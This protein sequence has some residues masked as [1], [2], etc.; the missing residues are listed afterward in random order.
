MKGTASG[1]LNFPQNSRYTLSAW[2]YSN[3]LDSA[4]H[5]IVA[6][7]HRQ[8]YLK[9]QIQSRY[10]QWEF[11]E[12]QDRSGW[13]RTGTPAVPKTWKYL[14]GVRDGY[15]Q[16]LYLDGTLV[17][18]TVIVTSDTVVRDLS[19]DVSIGRYLNPVTYYLDTEGY[20]WFNGKIDEVR[21]SGVARSA[22]WEKLCFMNQRVDDKLVMFR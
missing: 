2:I 1:K 21:I 20:C 12:Y 4:W 15:K 13:N 9:Q 22:E 11:V 16:Y 17:D 19:Q 5:A 6:K 18:S 14:T 3:T 10:G 7:G 8:Y